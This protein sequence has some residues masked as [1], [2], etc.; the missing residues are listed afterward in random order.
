MQCIALGTLL[1]LASCV[2]FWTHA[3]PETPALSA[4]SS[5]Q[6]AQ[7]QVKRK[8]PDVFLWAHAESGLGFGDHVRWFYLQVAIANAL[9]RTLIL[10]PWTFGARNR[11][12]VPYTVGLE[13]WFDVDFMQQK[14]DVVPFHEWHELS[15]G[16]VD[17]AITP[18]AR[19]HAPYSM[20]ERKWLGHCPVFGPLEETHLQKRVQ[21]RALRCLKAADDKKDPQPMSWITEVL[22]KE[23]PP[24]A[25]GD[26]TRTLG[27]QDFCFVD[28]VLA[29]T[30]LGRG[31]SGACSLM[32]HRSMYPDL[33]EECKQYWDIRG[34][35]RFN[36]EFRAAAES[37]IQQYVTG[38]GFIAIHWRHGD[39]GRRHAIDD[40]VA[41]GPATAEFVGE[42]ISKVL[43]QLQARPGHP[44]I[45]RI[46]LLTDATA[47]EAA[48]LSSW[49]NGRGYSVFTSWSAVSAL[50]ISALPESLVR[51]AVDMAIASR[52]DTFLH[53][54]GI[55]YFSRFIIEER[56]LL[57][58]ELKTS[59]RM[60]IRKS[61]PSWDVKSYDD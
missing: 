13:N 9:G 48:G 29:P 40:G 58:K 31:L 47:D 25:P 49:L 39:Y 34:A 27:L 19:G 54:L 42:K 56:V 11:D 17:V 50:Q 26:Q 3:S 38:D 43:T 33:P 22:A 2:Y 21:L 36:R 23:A 4:S 53:T 6:L 30:E 16:V 57:G 45:H 14:F 52:A 5:R 60:N 10:P 37:I 15:G 1:I 59:H 46:F 18:A 51:I 12:D 8:R 7:P 24:G 32:P 44:K 28:T 20:C 41:N 35:L 61:G 55:S